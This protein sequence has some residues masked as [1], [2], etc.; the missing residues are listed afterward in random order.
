MKQS[1]LAVIDI[2]PRTTEWVLRLIVPS[3]VRHE[4]ID[5][6]R[7]FS[8]LIGHPALLLCLDPLRD[9]ELPLLQRLLKL[10]YEGP[11]IGWIPGTSLPPETALKLV[12]HGVCALLPEYY[13]PEET[14]AAVHDCLATGRHHNQLLGDALLYGLRKNRVLT[15]RGGDTILTERET[16]AVGLRAE[17]RSAY[18]IASELCVSKKTVDKL[19]FRLYQRTGHKNFFELYAAVRRKFDVQPAIGETEPLPATNS[20][21]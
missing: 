4:L 18:E 13:T 1:K 9:W 10:G 19:F 7:L 8:G 14:A 17:G 6:E 15:C 11:I 16:K 5:T 21:K 2:H 12:N 20:L 3:G